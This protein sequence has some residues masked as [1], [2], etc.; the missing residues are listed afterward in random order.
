MKEKKQDLYTI[1]YIGEIDDCP[2]DQDE[3]KYEFKLW[4]QV[5]IL[6]CI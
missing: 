3:K 5:D 1:M 2:E 4:K 6:E